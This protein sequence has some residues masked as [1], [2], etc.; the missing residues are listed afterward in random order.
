MRIENTIK[1][2]V[3]YGSQRNHT[4]QL[5]ATDWQMAARR[6]NVISITLLSSIIMSTCLIRSATSQSSSYPIVLTRL[7]GS[8][9]RQSPHLKKVNKSYK[10][11]H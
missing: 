8:R 10:N 6:D 7:G 5:S 2:I 1:E 3:A 11:K 4:D 9:P